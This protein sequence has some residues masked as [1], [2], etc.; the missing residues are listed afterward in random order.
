MTE[1]YTHI[2]FTCFDLGNSVN[3]ND[4]NEDQFS[5]VGLTRNTHYFD[6]FTAW[7]SAYTELKG[8]CTEPGVFPPTID[9][10]YYV[11]QSTSQS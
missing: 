3:I 10:V 7:S 5:D 9:T 2:A 8:E 4:P 11:I 6:H 1:T